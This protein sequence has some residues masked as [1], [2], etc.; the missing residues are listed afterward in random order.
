M[1]IKL[2]MFISALFVAVLFSSCAKFP[3]VELNLATAAID[4]LKVIG[5]DLYVPVEFQAVEDSLASANVKLQVDKS[6]TLT[7]YK[8]SKQALALVVQMASDTKVKSLEVKS[9]MKTETEALVVDVKALVESNK[10]LLTKAPTGKEGK[11][12]LVEIQSEISSIELSVT[13][14]ETLLSNDDIFGAN[15]K[16]KAAQNLATEINVELTKVIEKTK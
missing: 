8:N 12:A 4:S 6:K 15:T 3:Q 5:A 9:V 1:K 16:I 7:T 11:A 2:M 10:V 13:E 14:A